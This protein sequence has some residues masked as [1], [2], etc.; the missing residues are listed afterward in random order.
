MPVYLTETLKIE[1]LMMIGFG[2][3]M[4]TQAEVAALFETRHPELP[5]LH[6]A[7]VGKIEAHF[8]LHGHLR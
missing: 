5:L 4:R 6:W 1:I 7:T 2:Y 3:R 8:R